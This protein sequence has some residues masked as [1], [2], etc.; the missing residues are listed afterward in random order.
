MLMG[1]QGKRMQ[2]EVLAVLSAKNCALSAYDVIEQLR[3]SYPRI[4]PT[5]VYRALA[6]LTDRGQVHRLESQN[7]FVA[8][9]CD[10]HDHAAIFSVCND[11]GVV[12]ESAAPAIVTDLSNLMKETGFTATRH[13]IEI[14]GLCASCD[15][16]VLPL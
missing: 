7:A 3:P 14:H 4:A 16:N 6:A 5:T 10:R 12:D 2:A 15:A 13:V 1:T 9:N 8:C 11:C